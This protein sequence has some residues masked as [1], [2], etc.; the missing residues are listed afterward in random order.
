MLGASIYIVPIMIQRN[1]PG[2]GP[3]VLTAFLFAS[4]PAVLAACAYAVLSTAMP[5]AGGSYLYASRGFNPY[6]GF[7]ASFSQWFGLCT[8]IGVVSF[9]IPAF[10]RDIALSGGSS[11]L[12]DFF[13]DGPG[14]LLT[15]LAL[16]WLFVWINIRG[17]QLYE[18]TI[19]PLMILMFVLGAIMIVAGFHYTHSDFLRSQGISANNFSQTVEFS[20]PIFLSASAI[21]F[22]SFIGFDSIAQAG[23]EA[24]NPSRNLPLAIG[25]S[26]AGVGLFYFLFTAA[27]YHAVPWQYVAD[28]AMQ[29]DLTAPGLMSGLLAPV[30]TVAIVTGAAVA[31]INDLPAMLLSVSRL[32]FAWAADGIFPSAVAQI[33]PAHHTPRNALVVSGLMASMSI[34]GCYLAGDFFLGVDIL[35]TSMLVNF[36]IMCISVLTIGKH[37]PMLA[38]S[39]SILTPASRRAV[40]WG[41]V[42]FLGGFLVIHVRKDL[43]ASLGEWYFHSTIIWIAVMAIG[44]MIYFYRRRR[45]IYIGIDLKNHFLH[46]PD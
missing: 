38:A 26:V 16:L 25:I 3:F 46:L 42:I 12:A 29:H 4:I 9:V 5:R 41:G 21:L 2:I 19:I 34:L 30:W 18:R 24:I 1:V 31:L 7:V 44:S 15:A 17:I 13:N 14:R 11:A 32:L 39:I 23:G 28:Q 40:A 33:H 45:L 8:A 27:V 10:L 6:F 43:N 36:I 35:V 37:N 20:W 22:S